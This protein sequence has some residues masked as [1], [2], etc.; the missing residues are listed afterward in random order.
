M[1]AEAPQSPLEPYESASLPAMEEKRRD[2]SFSLAD[3]SMGR[4]S[5]AML[6]TWV[7]A[8]MLL[9]FGATAFAVALVLRNGASPIVPLRLTLLLSSY[10]SLLLLSLKTC[11]RYD[12]EATLPPLREGLAVC[13]AVGLASVIF[14]I[15]QVSAQPQAIPLKFV[16]VA[17][18]VNAAALSS[19]RVGSRRLTHRRVAQGKSVKHALIVGGG[20]LGRS[21]ATSMERDSNLRIAVKGFVDDRGGK[22][23]DVLGSLDD[24]AN[25]ARAEF[26]DE[27]YITLPVMRPGIMELINCAREKH[28]SVKVVPP[29]L[30]GYGTFPVQFIGTHPAFTLH[31]EPVRGFAKFFKRLLDIVGSLILLILAA[32]LMAIIAIAVKL[33]SEGP[34][35]YCG[36][37][38]GFK[39]R[40]FKF[41]K[42][43]TMVRNADQ[44]KDKLRELN[45]REGPFFKITN[46]P[47]L[48]RIGSFLRATSMDELPQLFNVL[49]GDMSLVGPRP[50]PLDDYRQYRLE[51]RRRLDVMPGIT[52]LWQVTAR[53][54][55][56]F[57]CNM[58]LDL[59]YIDHWSF[60]LDLKILAK[61]I[62]AVIRKEGV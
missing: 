50:H 40:M 5:G 52:G 7:V 30:E 34:V 37:R 12:Q 48:T 33:D 32:P 51:H 11:G 54:D 36:D 21:L 59:Y 47:R 23:D 24:F 22:G 61:T 49:K 4:D 42:F 39:G 29:L 27:V 19:W 8:D 28:I 56:S 17:A 58:K 57:E 3:F 31:E 9:A 41:C 44:L 26:I 46:D 38:A 55:P 45:E 25:V 60:W 20:Q 14:L 35:L 2:I 53:A 62:P 6:S 43:R 13:K 15:V 16:A 18:I 1:A 10:A